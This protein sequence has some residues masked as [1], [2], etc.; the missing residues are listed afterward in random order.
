[1]I[2]PVHVTFGLLSE[3]VPD[4]GVALCEVETREVPTTPTTRQ[5]NANNV[6]LSLSG[7][8]EK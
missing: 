2:A 1:M 7:I 8:D 5:K 6:S 3:T 4:V